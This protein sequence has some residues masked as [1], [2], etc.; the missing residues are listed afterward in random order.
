MKAEE[1]NIVYMCNYICK[2]TK[3]RFI[4]CLHKYIDRFLDNYQASF[5]Y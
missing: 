4:V 1:P 2:S 3:T 5:D